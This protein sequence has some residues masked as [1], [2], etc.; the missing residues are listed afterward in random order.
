MPPLLKSLSPYNTKIGQL[1]DGVLK[2]IILLAVR[3]IYFKLDQEG[4]LIR[5]PKQK[6]LNQNL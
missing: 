3:F 5:K 1:T 2:I 4:N 6:K